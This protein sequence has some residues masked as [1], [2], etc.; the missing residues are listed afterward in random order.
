[1]QSVSSGAVAN[2]ISVGLFQTITLP[3]TAQKKGYV[4]INGNP[5]T[6]SVAY[7]YFKITDKSN[8]VQDMCITSTGGAQ[9]GICLPLEAGDKI[10][11]TAGSNYTLS[12]KFRAI[13]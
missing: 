2:A 9:Q 11:R 1:M 10:E 13:G 8:N 5:P 6:G 4:Y 3:Y 12:I 7:A